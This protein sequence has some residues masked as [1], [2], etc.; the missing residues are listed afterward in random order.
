MTTKSGQDY[1]RDLIEIEPLFMRRSVELCCR[2][3]RLVDDD[4]T[5]RQM[6]ADV[7]R[8]VLKQHTVEGFPD[9]LE[10]QIEDACLRQVTFYLNTSVNQN[11]PNTIRES[12]EVERLFNQPVVKKERSALPVEFDARAMWEQLLDVLDR[13]DQRKSRQLTLRNNTSGRTYF[14]LA[15]IL[16]VVTLL[17]FAYKR[18]D[19]GPDLI[20]KEMLSVHTAAGERTD[21]LFS[22]DRRIW[23]NERTNCLYPANYEKMPLEI[24]LAGEAYFEIPPGEQLITVHAGAF[25]FQSSAGS[26]NIEA[27]GENNSIA[28]SVFSGTVNWKENDKRRYRN[29]VDSAESVSWRFEKGEWTAYRIDTDP[30]TRAWKSGNIVFAHAELPYIIKTLEKCFMVQFTFD[31]NLSVYHRFT[32]QFK[33]ADLEDILSK[34]SFKIPVSFILVGDAY[35]ILGSEY[36]RTAHDSIEVNSP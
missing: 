8:R 10:Q 29:R 35:Q 7:F 30:N 17:I 5:A 15:A 9:N 26:F 32:G 16:A 21:L 34:I 19:V 23:L 18:N 6:V 1:I 12:Q 4:E 3:R 36:L 2:L 33:N 22:G 14:R 24:F 28:L 31:E 13:Q 27:S 20:A 11:R 25:S